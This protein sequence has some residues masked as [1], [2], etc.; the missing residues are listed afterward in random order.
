[1]VTSSKGRRILKVLSYTALFNTVIAIFLTAIGFGSPKLGSGGFIRTFVFSQCIGLS[2]C[3]LIMGSQSLLRPRNWVSHIFV[4]LG[5][6]VIGVFIG[7]ILGATINAINPSFF[8][9]EYPFLLR[10]LFGTILFATVIHYLFTIREKASAAETLAQE[11]RIKRLTSEKNAIET[12]LKLLQAQIE[13]HFL[14][15]TLSNIL[16]LLETDPAKGKSMLTDM[17]HYLRTS[18]S[19][20]REDIST[21]GQEMALIEDYLRIFKVRM[22]DRLD[23]RIDVPEG[24]RDHAFPP[25]LIQPLVENAI[26]HGVEPKIDGGEI[27]IRAE[28]KNRF[29]MVEVAD[30]GLGLHAGSEQGIGLK[31]IRERLQSLYGDKAQLVLEENSPTGMKAIIEVPNVPDQGDHSR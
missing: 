14:F 25:M 29:L 4:D 24:I 8:L 13:P 28:D 27:S 10:I 1:M 21:V 19:K 17:T 5:S 18:L 16:S 6:V 30:T 26:R 22:G 9:A 23:F 3:L 12:N 31:N 2:C 15:N 7:V 11:E 20:T